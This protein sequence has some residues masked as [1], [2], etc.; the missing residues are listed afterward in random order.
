MARVS[1]LS[2]ATIAAVLV[3]AACGREED[4]TGPT[5]MRPDQAVATGGAPLTAVPGRYIVVLKPGSGLAATPGLQIEQNN[6]LAGLAIV[7][8]PSSAQLA[9]LKKA[10][11]V[12]SVTQDLSVQWIPPASQMFSGLQQLSNP[13]PTPN[14]TN[15]SG[16]AFFGYQWNM[17]VTQ[18]DAAW[19]TTPGGAGRLVC[20]LDTGVDPGQLDLIG[21]VD[22]SRSASMV[23]A[24]P[25]IEDLNLHGTFVSGLI[26]SRGIGMASTAPDTRLCAVKVLGASGSGSFGDIINGIIFASIVKA[27]VIN[28]S[29]GAYV[30]TKAP[31][32]A[33]L[34]EALQHAINFANSERVLVVASS[35]NLGI[36]LDTDEPQLRSIPAQ[37]PGVLSVG[38]TAPIAQM[39]FDLLA[40]YSNYGGQTGIAMV[41]PG[42]DLVAG[43]LTQDLVLSACSRFTP[44]PFNCSGGVS[45]LFGAGTSFASPMVAGAAAVVESQMGGG[46]ILP[47]V[48]R[49]CLTKNADNVGPSSVF[50]RGR[51]NVLRAAA[52]HNH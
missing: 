35:G 3:V 24:E 30:N 11:N 10:P 37:L 14:G 43:G 16:A 21:K 41:A 15:Q 45:Y 12:T 26:S 29:L 13:G 5:S 23:A 31:G 9:S 51:L 42:G 44:P 27:D 1:V 39:N 50:G 46:R 8:N 17:R 33:G 25:F 52:C 19:G 47:S 22:L 40:S 34:I 36:N 4:S 48:V 6:A 7:R 38:A 20:V 18:A 2:A 28:M 32:V 49:T